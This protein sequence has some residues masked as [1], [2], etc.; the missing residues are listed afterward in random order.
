[1]LIFGHIG[2]G[3]TLL[4]PWR[5][6]LP[7]NILV[8]GAGFEPARPC[9]HPILNRTRM[10]SFATPARFDRC[11]ITTGLPGLRSRGWV[12][13][14]RNGAAMSYLRRRHGAFGP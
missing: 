3:K 6:E 12:D 8:P 7:A 11:H 5:K 1:M 2:I 9:G 14:T 13:G 10:P 4:S